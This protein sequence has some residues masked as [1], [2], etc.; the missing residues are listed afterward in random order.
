[1][2]RVSTFDVKTYGSLKVK[3]RTL[4]ITKCEASSNSKEKLKGD[5]QGHFHPSTVRDPDDVEDETRSTKVLGSPENVRD[6]QH[7]PTNGK[8]LQHHFP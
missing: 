2:K 5:G 4:V 1:M 3:R 7:S 8:F 6:F